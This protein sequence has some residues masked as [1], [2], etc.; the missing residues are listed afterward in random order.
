MK[1]DLPQFCLVLDWETTGAV[2]GGDSSKEYQGISFGAVIADIKTFTP[3]K[4]LYREIKFN[5]QKYKWSE[6]AEKIHGLSQEHLEVNGISQEEAAEDLAAFILEYFGDEKV[7]FGGH[8]AAFDISFT[9]QLMKTIDIAFAIENQEKNIPWIK[10]HH[11][12][13]DTS[14]IGM[15]AFKKFKSDALFEYIGLPARKDHN[16]L[17]DALN[18]LQVLQL[19]SEI[20]TAV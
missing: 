15:V 8:N 17:E 12:V 16:S 11:V 9:K 18:T 5:P 6:S 1:N 7:V 10:L 19:V 3:I 20:C 13:L 2:W 14:A 4:T